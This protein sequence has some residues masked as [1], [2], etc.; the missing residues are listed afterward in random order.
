MNTENFTA[1]IQLVE[2]LGLL[3]EALEKAL[4]KGNAR[5]VNKIKKEILRFQVQIEKLLE[6]EGI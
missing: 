6:G 4:E 1:L 2:S 3:S 5:K